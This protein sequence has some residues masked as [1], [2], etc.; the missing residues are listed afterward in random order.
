M[1]T[2][3]RVQTARRDDGT[4]LLIAAGELDLSN[5]ETFSEAIAS[6]LRAESATDGRVVIDL[7]EVEYLDSAAVNVLYDYA[8]QIGSLIANPLVMPVLKISGLTGVVTVEAPP[9]AES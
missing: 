4:L 5:V 8:D 3:L 1:A 6:A 2:S 7:S 9:S